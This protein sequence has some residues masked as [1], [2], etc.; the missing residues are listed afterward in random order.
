MK[1]GMWVGKILMFALIGISLAIV[2]VIGT[3]YLWNWLVPELFSGPVIN[4]W[5]TLGL[6]VLSKIFFSSFSKRCNC[7][8]GHS[9]GPWKNYWKAKWGSM[10]AEERERFKQKM[11][12]KW[13]YKDEENPAA[14]SGI[15]NG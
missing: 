11:K 12:E 6:L 10:P 13:C 1:R 4:F 8:Q 9:V 3:M 14:N 2:F 5:Q 7:H 15:A